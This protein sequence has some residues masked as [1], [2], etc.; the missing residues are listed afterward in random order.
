MNRNHYKEKYDEAKKYYQSIG[1]IKCP[2]LEFEYVRF[3]NIGFDHV[4]RR[5][6]KM[7]PIADQLRR[8]K[9]LKYSRIVLENGKVLEKRTV[10]RTVHRKMHKISAE[11]STYVNLWRITYTIDTISTISVVVQQIGSGAKHFLSIMDM[12]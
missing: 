6:R 7:R 5:N 3:S 10:K 2:C 11:T 8:F 9:L 4:L 1:S 12:K